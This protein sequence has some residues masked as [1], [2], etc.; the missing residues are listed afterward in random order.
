MKEKYRHPQFSTKGLVAYYKLWAG[1]TTGLTVHD[2]S[3]NGFV[4]T[5]TDPVI[6]PQ[7]PGIYF[8]GNHVINIGSGPSDVKTISE[9]VNP[10]S[11]AA[12]EEAI[13]LQ[14]GMY[15]SIVSGVVTVTGIAGSSL[16]VN[17]VLGTSGVTTVAANEWSHIA[18]T[19]ATANNASAL[20]IGKNDTDPFEGVIS[21]V[22]LFDIEKTA[23]EIKSIYE[24]TKWRYP[25]N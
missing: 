11:I 19:D 4:G 20:A 10:L 17:G 18:V 9:W 12:T 7:Y 24:L 8:N 23:A 14:V 1:F 6:T 13:R 5:A 22:A 21:H 3:G 2:Y 16:Y 15:I 25:N